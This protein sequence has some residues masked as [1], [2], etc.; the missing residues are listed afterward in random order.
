MFTSLLVKS[1]MSPICLLHMPTEIAFLSTT[2]LEHSD[3][4]IQ[5]SDSLFSMTDFYM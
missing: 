5:L 4:E 2:K 1:S 3:L